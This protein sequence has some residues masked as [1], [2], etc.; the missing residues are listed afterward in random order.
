MNSPT[1]AQDI[2]TGVEI[3]LTLRSFRQRA[4]CAGDTALQAQ[5][6]DAL[7][8]L[9]VRQD[10]LDDEEAQLRERAKT[11]EDSQ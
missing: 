8:A 9:G 5:I 6:D 2:A 4:I 11:G 10:I 7:R 1:T 3:A